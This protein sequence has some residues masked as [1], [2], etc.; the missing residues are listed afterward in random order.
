MQEQLRVTQ[1]HVDAKL[2]QLKIYEANTRMLRRRYYGGKKEVLRFF[3]EMNYCVRRMRT[4][5][6]VKNKSLITARNCF[7]YRIMSRIT[8]ISNRVRTH[9]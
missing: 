2:S 1:V 7:Q 6:R 8:R 4:L 9:A 3:R 5:K